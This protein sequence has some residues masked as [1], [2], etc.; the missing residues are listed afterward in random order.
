MRVTRSKVKPRLALYSHDAQGLGHMRRNLAIATALA[1][2]DE[3]SAL[4]ITGAKEAAAL[5]M[6][7]GVECL[8]LP[9]LS[10]STGG[11]YEPRSLGVSLPGLLRLRSEMI[12]SVLE[13]YE[14]DVLIVDKHPLGIEGELAAG[15]ELLHARGGTKLVL[16]LREVLDQPEV[17]AREWSRSGTEA[18][19]A[20]YYDAVWVYGDRDIFDPV[21]EY[22]LGPEV[23]A[24]VRFSGYL[25]RRAS[26]AALGRG[27][28][29]LAELDLA[30]DRVAAC[31]VGG[32]QDGYFLAEA[33][34]QAR[35]PDDMSAVLVT[36]P[37]M[38]PTLRAG[39]RGLS[40]GADRL[41]VVDFVE[42]P[43]ALLVR[44]DCVVSMGG[45]NTVC[46]LLAHG[47]DA[48]IVPRVEPRLEQL[49]RAERLRD[50]GLVDVLHPARLSPAAIGDWLAGDRPAR[51]PVKSVDLDGLLA[52]PG[53]LRDL[54]TPN[55]DAQ[56]VSG[57]AAVSA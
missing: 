45:Y 42:E 22:G 28:F 1:G 36:G 49:I 20:A 38:S 32:G 57:V 10:K 51:R 3:R 50:R 5:A 6:P 25:G 39:L 35:L 37:L 30:G 18:A 26:D 11:G 14:P 47:A 33:F 8:T 2:G 55:D 12:C 16:G 29:A 19:L 4:M 7:P 24:K 43:E 52:L 44:A 48:L 23:A 56:E 40:A 54:M 15:V 34:A 41:H 31:L 17:V 21:V 53:L 46:E 9:A 27:A 13:S